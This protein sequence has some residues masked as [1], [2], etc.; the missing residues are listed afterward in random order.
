MTVNKANTSTSAS[1][2]APVAGITYGSADTVNYTVSSTAGVS[3]QTATGTAS[4]VKDTGRSGGNTSFACD[5]SSVLGTSART[6]FSF[7]VDGSH[8]SG[9]QFSCTPTLA[10]T[11]TF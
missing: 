8:N 5:W 6:G 7:Q 1:Q 9:N 4:V 10:G 3:G 11:Y 2:S